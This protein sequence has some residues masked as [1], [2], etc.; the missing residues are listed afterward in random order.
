MRLDSF[1][2]IP[3]PYNSAAGRLPYN[4]VMAGMNMSLLLQ[5]NSRAILEEL[6]SQRILLLDGSMGAL[7]YSQEPQRGGL[8]RRA[9]SQPSPC[10]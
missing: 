8:S 3:Y 1:A 4:N 9:F 2:H 6:L 7:I 10:R 5:M